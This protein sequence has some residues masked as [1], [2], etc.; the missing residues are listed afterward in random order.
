[1]NRFFIMTIC[2]MCVFCIGINMC[3]AETEELN[4]VDGNV[5]FNA[6]VYGADKKQAPMYKV[7]CKP[8]DADSDAAVIQLFNEKLFR[9]Q[10]VLKITTE[11]V[12]NEGRI[13]EREYCTAEDIEHEFNS[14]FFYDGAIGA[15]TY[16]SSFYSGIMDITSLIEYDGACYIPERTKC[17]DLP[18]MT[19]KEAADDLKQVSMILA[20]NV[21]D[22]PYIARAY[23][24][25][26]RIAGKD[27]IHA[28]RQVIVQGVDLT[29]ENRSIVSSYGPNC[30]LIVYR[31]EFD[32][33]PVSYSYHYIESKDY[34]TLPS[35]VR[36]L[37]NDQGMIRFFAYNQFA[38]QEP[39][40]TYDLISFDDAASKVAL[41][42][43]QL[44]G[45]ELF[46]CKEISLEYVPLA[47]AGCNMEKEACLVPA[48][49]FYFESYDVSPILVNAIDGSIIN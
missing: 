44:L 40:E 3:Y 17:G 36:A 48:W 12:N 37:Y 4:K 14:L 49:V 11:Q 5:A 34:T 43:N 22:Q 6:K 32:G 27:G 30:Y 29:A 26:D 20:L 10:R 7:V 1:M 9:E 28:F 19:A 13:T 24:M 46:A 15:N 39:S 33:I 2:L 35:Y 42:L 47:Y 18:M 21:E 25:D 16:E 8:Y 41:H 45:V 38:I 31:F 23:S